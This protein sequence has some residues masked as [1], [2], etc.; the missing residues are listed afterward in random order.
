MPPLHHGA[1]LTRS[2]GGNHTS[3]NNVHNVPPSQFMCPNSALGIMDLLRAQNN[4]LYLDGFSQK[5]VEIL[6]NYLYI[7][8]N[9]YCVNR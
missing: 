5:D 9:T 6:L 2:Y 1:V 8:V 4:E 3:T 7:R